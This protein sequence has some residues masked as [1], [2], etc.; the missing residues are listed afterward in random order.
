M[1]LLI[2]CSIRIASHSISVSFCLELEM[3]VTLQTFLS[4]IQDQTDLTIKGCDSMDN[5]HQSEA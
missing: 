2:A 3:M 1:G 5:S 4:R